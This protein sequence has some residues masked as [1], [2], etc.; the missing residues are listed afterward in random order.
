MTSVRVTLAQLPVR[1]GDVRGNLAAV[2]SAMSAAEAL[3]ADLLITPE[4]AVTGY[5]CEDLLA[6]PAFIAAAMV[7]SRTAAAS[8]GSTVT[9]LGG[10]WHVSE[11]PAAGGARRQGW[12]A[13]AAPRALRNAGAV[14]HR[15]QVAAAHAKALLPTY[16]VFDDARHFGPG[17]RDQSLYRITT[18]SGPAVFGI[19]VC[20]D[21]WDST[22]ALELA[23]AGA[24]VL[25]V[26]NASPYHVGKPARR[27]EQVRAAAL[28]S[29]CPVAYV[30]SVGGQDE[31]VF[32]GGSF[33]VDADGTLL[34]RA[35]QLEPATLTVDVPVGPARPTT[36]DVVDLGPTHSTRVALPPAVV[37]PDLEVNQEVYSALVTGFGDYCRRVGLPRVILGLSG[38]IDS[39]LAAVIA[40]D[41]LGPDAVWGV[42]M[43]GPYS[44]GGSVTDARALAAN[45]GI[46][47]DV[48]EIKEPYLE[49]HAA[50]DDIITQVAGGPGNP[51]AWENLQARLRGTTLMT[52]ANATSSLVCTTGNRSE[53]AVG[54]FTLYGDSCGTAPNALG[55]LFKTTITAPDGTVLPGVYGLS[56]WRNERAAANGQV[57][58]IPEATL[59]K[60]ASAELAPD[61]Q[62]TDSLPPY[63]VLDELLLAFLEERVDAGALV[64]RLTARGWD[65][66]T[67]VAT[68]NRV[69]TLVDRSEF[70][71]RQ[72]PIRIKVSQ[73]AFGRD[74]RM[75]LAN[76]WSHATA[77]LPE[78]VLA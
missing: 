22:L 66:P 30:N 39:A 54:Y 18:P 9:V 17:A 61:Q 50:L 1:V 72:V 58:P 44:S 45:L 25:V 55:D 11:L 74:R 40:V 24:Q 73:V 51:V 59:S 68:V 38:G 70:K 67:A 34:A 46:R 21:V 8:A 53:S 69:V 35:P 26:L 77:V 29:G 63:E 10:P 16:S 56:R 32:D 5:P 28:A 64:G 6:E 14:L 65:T 41:A 7:A 31:L 49:R 20:E 13:D 2:E 75:P 71:R 76:D 48:V 37:A 3:D 78:P 33:V 19:L 47:F 62:D 60:P 12:A 36:G 57:A 52:L 43:P 4:M 27:L 15:G 42:G 23:Q